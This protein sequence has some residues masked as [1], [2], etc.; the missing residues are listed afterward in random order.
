MKRVFQLIEYVAKV[1]E[2]RLANCASPG[3]G[4]VTDSNTDEG[5]LDDPAAQKSV[6]A[7]ETDQGEID[8]LVDLEHAQ[9]NERSEGK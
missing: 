2:A 7:P 3:Q 6:D 9:V 1:K 5:E 4:F 8:G